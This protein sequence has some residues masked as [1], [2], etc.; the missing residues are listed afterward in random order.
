MTRTGRPVDKT[1]SSGP[2]LEADEAGCFTRCAA[3][4]GACTSVPRGLRAPGWSARWLA[5][6][7][8]WHCPKR[9]SRLKNRKK[10][11]SLTRPALA[12]PAVWLPAW[13]VV[14]R[15]WQAA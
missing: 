10:T 11:G 14:S 5:V 12:P 15:S 9:P 2:S 3:T 13:L 6:L 8:P 4:Y 1:R 7:Q